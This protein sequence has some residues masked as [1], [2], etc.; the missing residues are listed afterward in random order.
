MKYYEVI[1]STM[2]YY[3]VF[4]LCTM[5][6]ILISQ[7]WEGEF[8]VTQT[9]VLFPGIPTDTTNTTP[10]VLCRPTYFLQMSQYTLCKVLATMNHY[11]GLNL[12]RA[13]HGPLHPEFAVLLS[14]R[15]YTSLQYSLVWSKQ[16]A[17]YI[18]SHR[19]V[20]DEWLCLCTLRSR[21]C[22]VAVSSSRFLLPLCFI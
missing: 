13:H 8:W 10:G 22:R 15:T 11:N 7:G 9:D 6:Y 21:Q 3:E 18:G 20:F 2:K 19:L 1:R 17:G 5:K 16:P 14:I 12:R 4:G